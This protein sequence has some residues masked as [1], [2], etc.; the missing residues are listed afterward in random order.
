MDLGATITSS[1]SGPGSGLGQKAKHN[2]RS[3]D[4]KTYGELEFPETA[5]LIFPGLDL[6]ASQEG[7][8]V[9]GKRDKL[10]MKGKFVDE[11]FDRRAQAKFVRHYPLLHLDTAHFSI[12]LRTATSVLT[13]FDF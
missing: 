13:G 6:L 2:F 7:E 8:E 3:S 12:L 9:T 5:P 11:Y 10:K 1:I 4:G